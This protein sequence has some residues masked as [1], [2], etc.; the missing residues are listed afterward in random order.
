MNKIKLFI[1]TFSN[2]VSYRKGF[3]KN[4][5]RKTQDI[6]MCIYSVWEAGKNGRKKTEFKM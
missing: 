3:Q 5:M 1:V 4:D 2:N 6:D